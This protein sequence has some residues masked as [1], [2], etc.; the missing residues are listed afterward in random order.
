[1]SYTV[2]VLC[3]ASDNRIRGRAR[4]FV[5]EEEGQKGGLVM[6][7]KIISQPLSAARMLTG[8]MSEISQP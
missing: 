7:S 6:L 2:Q 5:E 3:H 8:L 4:I 1:M